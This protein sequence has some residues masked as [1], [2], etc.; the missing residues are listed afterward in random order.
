MREFHG[1]YKALDQIADHPVEAVDV[2]V[3]RLCDEID[4]SLLVAPGF[5]VVDLGGSL[6]VVVAVYTRDAE[7]PCRDRLVLPGA[8]RTERGLHHVEY[9][10][11]VV[12]MF[13]VCW[14]VPPVPVDIPL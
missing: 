2:V 14:W 7:I 11:E 12:E 5:G 1:K 9:C 8:E 13:A 6:L 3:A 4:T 10:F